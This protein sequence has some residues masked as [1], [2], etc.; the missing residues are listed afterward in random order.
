MIEANT[1]E[2]AASLT[3][4]AMTRLR[5]PT[6]RLRRGRQN[7][8]VRPHPTQLDSRLRGNDKIDFRLRWNDKVEDPS[9]PR[10]KERNF[11]TGQASG[12]GKRH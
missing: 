1:Y 4:L 6:A 3:L 5:P 8:G 10:I 12:G 11:G 2:I 7:G 9:R